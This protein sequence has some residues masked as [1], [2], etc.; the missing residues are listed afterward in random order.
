VVS[1]FVEMYDHEWR[2]LDG[3]ESRWTLRRMEFKSLTSSVLLV[4][5]M[6]A[7]GGSAAHI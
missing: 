3:C 1:F 7:C 4:G 6:D 2:Q 5:N